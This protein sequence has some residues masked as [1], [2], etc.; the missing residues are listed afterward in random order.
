M[1]DAILAIL[2][3]KR[4]SNSSRQDRQHISATYPLSAHCFVTPDRPLPI[5]SK[6][7]GLDHQVYESPSSNPLE[8]LTETLETSQISHDFLTII[9]ASASRHLVWNLETVSPFRKA[10]FLTFWMRRKGRAKEEA[11]FRASLADDDHPTNETAHGA[12]LSAVLRA[13]RQG[14]RTHRLGNIR[15]WRR[16]ERK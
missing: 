5:S 4:P 3:D 13:P 8:H 16:G 11:T 14:P 6:R 2:D 7:S 12:R 9:P 1:H 10:T 15:S